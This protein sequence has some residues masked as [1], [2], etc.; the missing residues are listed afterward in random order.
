MVASGYYPMVQ[1]YM[2]QSSEYNPAGHADTM[3]SFQQLQGSKA[4]I[5]ESRSC[6]ENTGLGPFQA[7]T[8]LYHTTIYRT[9]L[10]YIMLYN[11]IP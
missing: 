5:A 2:A 3:G 11:A 7:V 9:V 6:Q 8:S 10:Y 1:A 4:W